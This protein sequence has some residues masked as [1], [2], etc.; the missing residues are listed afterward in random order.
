MEV[1]GLLARVAFGAAFLASGALK[2]RDPDW[3]AAARWFGAPGWLVPLVA[4]AE[5]VLGSLLM[6]GFAMPLTLLAG[7]LLLAAYTG[8]L[9]AV[10]RRPPARRPPCACFG[11]RS[12]KPVSGRT[13]VRN[14]ALMAVAA[15]VL[16]A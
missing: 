5:I 10:L 6:V 15:L 9:A 12:S 14:L 8:L 11:W 7:M 13:V 1:V 2:L 4:P 16:V 3:P